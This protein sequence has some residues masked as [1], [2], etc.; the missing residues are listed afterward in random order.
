M[1]RSEP[2]LYRRLGLDEHCSDADVK[3]KYRALALK[4]H[5][6]KGGDPEEFKAVSEAYAVLS[7]AEKRSVYDATGEAE[8][9]DFDMEEF[10]NSGVLGD[11][12]AEMMGQSGMAEEMA[13]MFGDEMDM[14]DMQASAAQY[15][16]QLRA[17]ISDA[18]PSQLCRRA[19]SPSSRRR[20]GWAT[21]RCSCPTAPRWTR[22]ACRRWRRWRRSATTTTKRC[23]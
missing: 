16:V 15:S 6:D 19:S 17:I 4:L 3:K 18:H 22:R 5:P 12:F 10:L 13:E 8:L 7:S 1:L 9:A 21:G 11:F 20:W 14:K 2:N 23:A